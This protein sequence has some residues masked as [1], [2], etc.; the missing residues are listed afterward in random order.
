MHLLKL[1]R[2]LLRRFVTKIGDVQ[3]EFAKKK[4]QLGL[5]DAFNWQRQLCKS[6][7]H[8]FDTSLGSTK[9]DKEKDEKSKG[10]DTIAPR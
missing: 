2:C 1:A 3:V 7:L 6:C 4:G 10:Q 9:Y 8:P 5:V